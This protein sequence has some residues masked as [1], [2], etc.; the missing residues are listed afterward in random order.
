MWKSSWFWVALLISVCF[1]R[2]SITF[3][4]E[5]FCDAC[6]PWSAKKTPTSIIQFYTGTFSFHLFCFSHLNESLFSQDC[7]FKASL[8]LVMRHICWVG[9]AGVTLLM[10]MFIKWSRRKRASDKLQE[11]ITAATSTVSPSSWSPKDI[12]ITCSV[13]N[14]FRKFSQKNNFLKVTLAFTRYY[15]MPLAED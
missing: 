2:P 7:L 3:S 13:R 1:N 9:G 5:S 11:L 12:W 4:W 14:T 8:D 6:R 15:W 10:A